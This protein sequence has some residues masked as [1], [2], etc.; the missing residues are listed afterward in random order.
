M[1]DSALHWTRRDDENGATT[2]GQSTC[3]RWFGK[4]AV[5]GG[6]CKILIKIID[7]NIS[8]TSNN[9]WMKL[10][11]TICG[12]ECL[13]CAIWKCVTRQQEYFSPWTSSLLVRTVSE[14]GPVCEVIDPENKLIFSEC[15]LLSKFLPPLSPHVPAHSGSIRSSTSVARHLDYPSTTDW[16][17]LISGHFDNFWSG[18]FLVLVRDSIIVVVSWLFLIFSGRNCSRSLCV[19]LVVIRFDCATQARVQSHSTS[20]VLITG[21]YCVTS[22]LRRH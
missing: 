10:L 18:R 12:T 9:F 11:H 3:T 13:A 6:N 15:T 21:N 17:S 20:T 8:S 4:V 1:W 2:G 19:H 7:R 16:H 22:F 14:D 5:V